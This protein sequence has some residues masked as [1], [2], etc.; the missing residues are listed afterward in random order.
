[1]ICIAYRTL[2][3]ILGSILTITKQLE[4]QFSQIITQTMFEDL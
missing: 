4:L 3:N 1:L 2:I